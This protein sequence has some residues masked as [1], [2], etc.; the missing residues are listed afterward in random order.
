MK[1]LFDT[2]CG[3]TLINHKLVKELKQ[4]REKKT[5]W[6]TKAGKFTT[7]NKCNV[8][9]NLPAFHEHREITWNCYVDPTEP[10]TICN[11]DMIIGRDL[12]HEIGINI[13]FK[14]GIMEWDN[15]TTPMQSIDKLQDNY[16]EEFEQELMFTHDPVTTDAERIQN[17]IN[18]KYKK[19]DLAEV[20]KEC[21]TLDKAEQEKLYKMLKKFEHLFDGTLGTWETDPIDLELKDP[22]VKPYHAKPY[23]V[24]HAHE[25]MLREEMDRLCSYGVVRKINR[26][27]WASPVFTV[28]K[29]DTSLRSIA[30]LREVNKNIK[31]KPFP[32]PKISELLQKL[33]GFTYATSLDLNMGYYHIALTPN[34]SKLCTVVLPWGKY[35][36]LK[37][38]MG[39]C[40]SPDIFQE[41]MSDLMAGLEFVRAYL[42]DLLVVSK[43]SFEDHLNHIEQVCNR[44]AEAGLKV[45]VSKSHFCKHEL[46]YLGYLIN[47]EGV[48]P[49]MKKVEA[50]RNIAPPKT[51]KQLRSFIGMVNYYRDMWPRRSHLIAP[52]SSLTSKNVKFKWT[53]EHQKAFDDVKLMIAQET[54]L[55]Y[56]D[57]SKPFH[58][59]TDASKR[60]LGAWISQD[61]K[62][63][64][65]YSRKLN[66]AQTRYTTTE[67]E[68]LSIVETLKEFRSILLGQQIIVHTDHENLTHKNFNCD[69]VMRWRLFIEEYSPDLRYIKGEHNVV[70]DAL[71]RLE[72]LDQTFDDST[73]MYY[74]VMY[75]CFPTENESYD[76]HP[77]SYYKLDQAQQRDA[78][79]KKILK[80]PSSKYDIKDFHGGGKTRSLVCYN[81]KIVV[82]TKLQK[83]VIDW[84][85]TVLCHPGI[86]RTEESISQ[87]LYWPKMRDQITNYVQACPTC[88]KN[89]RKVKKYGWLPPKEAEAE[90]WDKLCIDL[91]GPYKIRR[92][93][94]DPLVCRCVTMIVPA[95]GWFEIHEYDDI[96]QYDTN[97][98]HVFVT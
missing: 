53:A 24:P 33:E 23:P 48:R 64:A 36:Y 47:R 42:D 15:A 38:P 93:G 86:N 19:A 56:P 11:Y 57:F 70:A 49:T 83:H 88:Q 3:S 12:M 46:E 59:R 25:Q 98:L 97:L 69:R 63:I 74:S 45:N 61:G 95:T 68:L 50:I 51:R 80:H 18:A 84:Y 35:E 16:L 9:F 20:V 77:V 29:T 89:K 92:K 58:I 54:L 87:H 44:L 43:G 34:A 62:P 85:H 71:S 91:I 13:L 26:S 10:N 73:E 22:N 2:G 40:N 37:L 94:Q 65:F 8:T 90:P 66:P 75:D 28:P 4:T 52:L 60:Q 96:R 39:L 6:R 76:V 14:E 1:V 67:R 7:S 5:K 41:K 55:T 79:I 32:L 17:I 30:D 81:D 21:E 31:R 82:P 72:R 78:S 27:E